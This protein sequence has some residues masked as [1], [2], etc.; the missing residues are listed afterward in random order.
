[1]TPLKE[2]GKNSI[3]LVKRCTKPDRKGLALLLAMHAASFQP[4]PVPRSCLY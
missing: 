4:P 3:R 2:F 1:M